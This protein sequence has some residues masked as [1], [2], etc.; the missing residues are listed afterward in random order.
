MATVTW[1]TEVE[2]AGSIYYENGTERVRLYLSSSL[3]SFADL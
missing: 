3:L 1:A 2:T